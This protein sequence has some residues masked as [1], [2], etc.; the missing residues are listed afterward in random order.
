MEQLFEGTAQLWFLSCRFSVGIPNQLPMGDDIHGSD[1]HKQCHLRHCIL[2]SAVSGFCCCLYS[3]LPPHVN[4]DDHYTRY[5]FCDHL[6]L[7]VQVVD[8][9]TVRGTSAI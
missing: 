1:R 9:A 3:K 8:D 4:R 5:V 2:T 7:V 6:G